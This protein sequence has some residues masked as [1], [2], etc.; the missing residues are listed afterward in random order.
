MGCPK[1]SKIL[2]FTVKGSEGGVSNEPRDTA[3]A[4]KNRLPPPVDLAP[5][6]EMFFSAAR[7]TIIKPG[8]RNAL[9]WP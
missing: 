5:P 4:V 9:R 1:K 3:H 2:V 6:G 7:C 8:G